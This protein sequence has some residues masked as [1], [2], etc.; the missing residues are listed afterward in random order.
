MKIAGR[1]KLQHQQLCNALLEIS[2]QG[3]G[4]AIG[5]A[6]VAGIPP[7]QLGFET[8][9]GH[10]ATV[11]DKEALGQV[12]SEYFGFPCQSLHRLQ[13]THT[14]DVEVRY[15]SRAENTTWDGRT[16]LGWTLRTTRV[17][18][19]RKAGRF[20]FVWTQYWIVWLNKVCEHSWA[21]SNWVSQD[22]NRLAKWGLWTFLSSSNWEFLKTWIVWPNEVC[23]HSWAASNWEFL[24]THLV[25]ELLAITNELV[26][27]LQRNVL[28]A[29]GETRSA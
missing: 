21:A 20:P 16:R 15:I 7:R 14:Y 17:H 27:I 9:Q 10:V 4:R 5:Q 26:L 1:R 28:S 13:H 19:A 25:Q 11:V 22:M 6:V 2:N 29:N 12:S 23:E 18:S 3:V 8:G 24:K